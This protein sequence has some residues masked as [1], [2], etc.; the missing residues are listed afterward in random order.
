MII[1]NGKSIINSKIDEK[2]YSFQNMF[3]LSLMMFLITG[4]SFVMDY[5]KWI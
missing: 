5:I 2:C 3:L 4:K 1:R